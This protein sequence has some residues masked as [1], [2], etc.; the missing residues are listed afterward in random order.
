[1]GITEQ[2]IS[3]DPSRIWCD[4]YTMFINEIQAFFY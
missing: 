4:I 3:Y 1:M 2:E